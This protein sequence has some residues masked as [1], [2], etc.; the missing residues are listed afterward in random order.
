MNAI[1]GK[2]YTTELEHVS[3]IFGNDL[4]KFRLETQL[5]SF[6][7]MFDQKDYK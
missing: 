5:V 1:K 2:D 4:N 7:S 6:Q 3:T